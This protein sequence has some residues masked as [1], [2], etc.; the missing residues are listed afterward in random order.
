MWEGWRWFS[1]LLS[2]GFVIVVCI[3][4]WLG[5]DFLLKGDGVEYWLIIVCC[6]GVCFDW[7]VGVDYCWWIYFS[8]GCR[9]LSWF[10]EFVV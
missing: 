4:V 2:G 6:G 7:L 9:L 10:C 3:G 8:I 1:C 5:N